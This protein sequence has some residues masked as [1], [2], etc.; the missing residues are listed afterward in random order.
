[1]EG[2]EAIPRLPHACPTSLRLSD[3]HPSAEGGGGGGGLRV[4]VGVVVG[5]LCD[6]EKGC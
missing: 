3:S 5:G 6:G 4:V 2:C 1:M